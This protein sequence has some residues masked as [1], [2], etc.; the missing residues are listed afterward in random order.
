MDYRLLMPKKVAASRL[1]LTI[2]GA[3]SLGTI[4]FARSLIR[5]ACTGA[6]GLQ[7]KQMMGEMDPYCEMHFGNGVTKTKVHKNGGNTPGQ[8]AG[9]VGANL[10]RVPRRW[11]LCRISCSPA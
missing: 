6:S 4:H 1:F 11:Y 5:R 2:E 10:V 3:K 7:N 8:S 9:L